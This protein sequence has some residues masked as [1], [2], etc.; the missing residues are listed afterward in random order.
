MVGLTIKNKAH[1]E[2]ILFSSIFCEIIRLEDE[3]YDLV[4]SIQHQFE[5][6]E[7]EVAGELSHKLVILE[8]RIKTLIDLKDRL[9]KHVDIEPIKEE[10]D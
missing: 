7:H 6:E 5:I 8:S 1:V 4:E 3:R 2:N 9:E 10:D